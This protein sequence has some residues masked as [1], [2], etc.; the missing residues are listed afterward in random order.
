MIKNLIAWFE[1]RRR[2]SEEL[3]FHTD[4]LKQEFIALGCTRPMARK[5]A[6]QRLGSARQARQQAYRELSATVRDLLVGVAQE[7]T[8]PGWVTAMAV[9]VISFFV[10]QVVLPD[11][12]MVV[13]WAIWAV[14]LFC[15]LS[16][17]A[18]RWAQ[19]ANDWRYHAYSI[20]T[21]IATA[22]VGN[23]IWTCLIFIWRLSV[24]PT[25]G[26]SV[27]I[28]SVEIIGYLLTCC[29]LLRAWSR[30]RARRCRL[31]ACMLRLPD[32]TGRVGSLLLDSV[33]RSS[34]CIHGHGTLTANYWHSDWHSYG[35]FWD[36]FFNPSRE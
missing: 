23:A 35:P 29:V 33:T 26:W 15:S 25:Q 6:R 22:L 21:L 1:R 10:S 16:I 11:V 27:T 19:A 3:R 24:W 4:L 5:L 34:I 17:E 8:G 9:G 18:I 31:C 30:N 13:S 32:E 14:V 36:E 12:V 7:H 20:V 28:F 2:V